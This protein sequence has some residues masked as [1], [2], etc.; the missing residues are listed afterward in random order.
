MVL[1]P[2]SWCHVS[3]DDDQNSWHPPGERPP[4]VEKVKAVSFPDTASISVPGRFIIYT[5]GGNVSLCLVIQDKKGCCSNKWNMDMMGS[6]MECLVWRPLEPQKSLYLVMWSLEIYSISSRSVP[7][8][9]PT[10]TAMKV[11]SEAPCLGMWGQCCDSVIIVSPAGVTF[12]SPELASPRLLGFLPVLVRERLDQGL[13]R[14]F[15]K[16]VSFVVTVSGSV[17]LPSRVFQSI[18]WRY[19]L[20]QYIC[21]PRVHCFYLRHFKTSFRLAPSCPEV[22]QSCLPVCCHPW[23][24]T[25]VIHHW[26][27]WVAVHFQSLNQKIKAHKISDFKFKLESKYFA[28]IIRGNKP[29]SFIWRSSDSEYWITKSIT[30]T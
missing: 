23:Y 8:T 21:S 9:S 26:S 16:I 14:K 28:S 17:F 20:P 19:K 2:V 4:G 27:D 7:S 24:A 13:G 22:L 18:L 12:S 15:Y 11:D 6:R 3:D 1:F 25:R 30:E 5:W 29:V 10:Q